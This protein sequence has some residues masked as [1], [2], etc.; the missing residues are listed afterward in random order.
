[1]NSA[2]PRDSGSGVRWAL[3]L[4][5]FCALLISLAGV[6][7]QEASAATASDNFNRAN[8]TLSGSWTSISDG[9]LKITSQAVA[10]SV[11]AGYSGATWNAATFGSNQASQVEVTSAQLT[12]GQWIGP[13]VRAQSGGQNTY[14]GIYFW[15]SGSPQLRL[16]KR[17]SG[18]WIQL[19]ASYNSGALA[20]GTQLLL[21]ASGSSITFLQNGVAR[22]SVT[23]TS[24]TGGAPGIMAYG[25]GRADNWTGATLAASAAYTVGGTVSGL[26]GGTLVLQDNGGDLLTITA[27]GQ[28]TFATGLPTGSGYSVGVSS[29]P[30][31]QTCAI[32]NGTGTIAAASITNVSVTCSAASSTFEVDYQ[33]TDANGVA[34]Y[35]TVSSDNGSTP[36]VMRV[37]AP[38]SPAPGVPH[39]F[40]FVLP[41]EA[42]NGTSFG[43]GLDVMRQLDAQDKYNLTIIEPSFALEPWY[44][45]NPVNSAAQQETFV[46]QQLVPWVQVNLSTTG[47]EQNWLIGFSKSGIG[48][49]DLILKHPGVFNL[50]ASWDFPADMQTYDQYGSS[51]ASSYGTN[52]NFQANYE[53]TSAFLNAHKAPFATASRIWIGGYEAFQTDDSDYDSLLTSVGIAHLTETPTAMPHRWDG[54]WV[55]LAL[56]ALHQESGNLPAAVA[57]RARPIVPRRVRP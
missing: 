54:G 21:Q 51:S 1:M 28:F 10:G 47:Q 17:I 25:T 49:Q 53:L 40:L 11:G 23:D 14:L 38:A 13:A 9:A 20:A 37:L 50:A 52:A 34:S 45:D 8:G 22:V 43:D 30:A 44:A 48:G 29:S 7:A 56:A 6:T 36:E 18:S 32:A 42:D 31:G 4:L 12:G 26:S 39:N 27:N 2:V 15:N 5:V 24:L 55:P 19:G 35:S 57:A 46:I 3:R 33:G 41:V 16:Y